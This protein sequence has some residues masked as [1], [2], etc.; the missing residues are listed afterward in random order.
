MTDLISPIGTVVR[1]LCLFAPGG[2]I[3]MIMAIHGER[4]NAPAT[5][6]RYFE[7]WNNAPAESGLPVSGGIFGDFRLASGAS[8]ST[9]NT[10]TNCDIAL[11][12]G[13]LTTPQNRSWTALPDSDVVMN[14]FAD[15]G[16][17]M[18]GAQTPPLQSVYC[19]FIQLYGSECEAALDTLQQ[20]LATGVPHK[21]IVIDRNAVCY[22]Q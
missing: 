7:I 18:L 5:P 17:G 8:S 15:Q 14:I 6:G 2:I 19:S 13:F 3:D 22:G 16:V 9:Y 21:K 1:E 4:T 12:N 10:S 20:Q 11:V